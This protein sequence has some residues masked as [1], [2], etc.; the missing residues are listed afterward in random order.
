MVGYVGIVVMVGWL[1]VKID[2]LGKGMWW[3]Q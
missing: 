2:G 3:L 1:V